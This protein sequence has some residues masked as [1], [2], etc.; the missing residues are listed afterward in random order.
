MANGRPMTTGQLAMAAHISPAYVVDL[1]LGRRDPPSPVVVLA[2]S[3]ALKIPA[4]TLLHASIRQRG[5]LEL[6]VPF[7]ATGTAA[8]LAEVWPRM[9]DAARAALR[10]AL[11][12][13]G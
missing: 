1:E 5:W 9:D 13:R 3:E 4:A 10:D 2:I 6:Q 12:G 8:I 7:E 11:R